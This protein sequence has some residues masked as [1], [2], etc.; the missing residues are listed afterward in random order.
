MQDND[1]SKCNDF[2]NQKISDIDNNLTTTR[3]KIKEY[4]NIK[5]D[6]EEYNKLL[7]EIEEFKKND[8]FY[9]NVSK[10]IVDK[11]NELNQI[12][13]ELIESRK[14]DIS[15]I[16]KTDEEIKL[17]E[18]KKEYNSKVNLYNSKV[19]ENI[20]TGSLIEIYKNKLSNLQEELSKNNKNK[21]I[22]IK[23]PKCETLVNEDDYKKFNKS[24]A[25]KT[26][27]IKTQIDE[28]NKK[29]EILKLN[30]LKPLEEFLEKKRLE[31]S[32]LQENVSKTPKNVDSDK[33]IELQK[34]F[35]DLQKELHILK[36]K[37]E[38]LIQEQLEQRRVKL[39]ELNSKLDDME[40]NK[41]KAEDIEIYLENEKKTVHLGSIDNLD[42][43]MLYLQSIIERDKDKESLVFLNVDYKEKNPYGRYN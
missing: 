27:E 29:L 22:A 6:E 14:N 37:N 40:L 32:T 20:K 39:Q 34:K 36:E 16:V 3:A 33:T 31:I 18:M 9:S 17:S 1:F 12:Q 41:Q 28:T 8:Y 30:D 19:N 15:N 2:Y 25:D 5:F 7:S 11:T 23:C 35:D 26:K 24:K 4:K 38:E 10:D 13:L 43:K 21:F 42:I